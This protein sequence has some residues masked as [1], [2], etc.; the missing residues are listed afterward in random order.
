MIDLTQGEGNKRVRKRNKKP[1]KSQ[2]AAQAYRLPGHGGDGSRP[3]PYPLPPHA[4]QPISKEDNLAMDCDDD[5]QP[6]APPVQTNFTTKATEQPQPQHPR[7]LLPPRG[8]TAT[9]LSPSSSSLRTR[10]SLDLD[11]NI[12]PALRVPVA[13]P[14]SGSSKVSHLS[15]IT[16]GSPVV[17]TPQVQAQPMMLP[18]PPHHSPYHR[19]LMPHQQSQTRGAGRQP[20]QASVPT[21]HIP[22]T[23]LSMSSLPHGQT[24]PQRKAAAALAQQQQSQQQRARAPRL[25]PM[26]TLSQSPDPTSSEPTYTSPLPSSPPPTASGPPTSP[27]RPTAGFARFARAPTGFAAAPVFGRPPPS[28]SLSTPIRPLVVSDATN[29]SSSSSSS[30]SSATAPA[31]AEGEAGGKRRFVP[32]PP[33][34]GIEY[35][36]R[37]GGGLVT[38]HRP[39]GR[40]DECTVGWLGCL[41]RV[42]ADD[43]D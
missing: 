41:D 25:P 40:Y 30:S 18:R 10:G 14:T 31:A 33:R 43:T 37:E 3:A 24:N 16:P 22:H 26:R 2:L 23:R 9:S 6:Q 1:T 27:L 8:A 35:V 36:Q 4:R 20:S 28:A 39:S 32:P 42:N 7:A 12:D 15:H 21:S 13:S 38:A 17:Q 19:P 34:A 5:F 11:A 29:T